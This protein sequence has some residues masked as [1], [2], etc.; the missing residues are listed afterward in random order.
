MSLSY[1]VII[2]AYNAERTIDETL[3]SVLNQTVSP[4]EIVVVDDGSTDETVSIAESFGKSVRVLRQSNSGP[5]SATNRGMHFVTADVFALLDADDLW[6]SDKMR[7]QLEVLSANPDLA[8]VGCKMRQFL[9]GQA[10]DGLGEVREGLLRSVIAIRRK[11]YA[12]VGDFVDTPGY[13]G[14]V[15]DWLAR[16]REKGHSTLEIDSVLA[17]RRVISGSLSSK[18]SPLRNTGYLKAAYLS[19][20]RRKNLKGDGGVTTP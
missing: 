12:D 4:A 9:H 5:G 8:V 10:D 20:L 17:L 15:I 1:A 14:E 13:S 3:R 19:M 7:Q 2:P 6:L 16:L 18:T 11:V